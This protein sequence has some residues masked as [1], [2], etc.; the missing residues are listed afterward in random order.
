MIISVTQIVII[1]DKRIEK[2]ASAQIDRGGITKALQLP[3]P[4]NQITATAR[5]LFDS[6]DCSPPV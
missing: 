4:E 3:P 2:T 1:G 5:A 6:L